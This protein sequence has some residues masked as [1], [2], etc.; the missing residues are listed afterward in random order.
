MTWEWGYDAGPDPERPLPPV[1]RA[2]FAE[3]RKVFACAYREKAND[4]FQPHRCH[5][6]KGDGCGGK[7]TSSWNCLSCVRAASGS[8]QGAHPDP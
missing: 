5:A 8:P 4:G 7:F 2:T 1:E 3:L 6:G